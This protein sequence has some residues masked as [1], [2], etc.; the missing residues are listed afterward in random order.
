[1]TRATTKETNPKDS[2]AVKKAPLSNVPMNVI[3]E[4]GVAMLEGAMK[5]GRFNWRPAGARASVYYDALQ[6]HMTA[7][8]DEG[9]N[10]DADSGISHITKAIATLVVLRDAM[11][12]GKMVDDRP[13]SGA[14]SLSVLNAKA[15][16]IVERY[17]D[18]KPKH[19]TIADT[20]GG[21]KQ[22]E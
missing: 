17:G 3:M 20:P 12:Q 2:V 11:M 16:E 5:Y 1:M 18:R 19:W 9:E 7:W 13:P 14:A 8:W 22:A 10:I 4:L 6:R 21:D 15:A